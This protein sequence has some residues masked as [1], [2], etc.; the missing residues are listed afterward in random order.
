MS[1][2]EINQK[3]NGIG[4]AGTIQLIGSQSISANKASILF[5]NVPQSFN[6]LKIMGLART[7]NGNTYDYLGLS[8]SG[9]YGNAHFAFQMFIGSSSTPSA[10]NSASFTYIEAGI[11]PGSTATASCGGPFVINL[12]FY[13]NNTFFKNCSFIDGNNGA[14][15][16]TFGTGQ[17]F[18]SVT[19]PINSITLQP[20]IGANFVAGSQFSLYGIY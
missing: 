20:G 14:T 12:P 6:H 9:D 2:G 3:N 18:K 13:T 1:L 11:I 19:A 4:V 17:W 16:C 15:Y 7:D 8:F 5:D 10:T